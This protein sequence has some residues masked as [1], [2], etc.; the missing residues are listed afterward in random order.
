[1]SFIDKFINSKLGQG[2]VVA[3]LFFIVGLLIGLFVKPG[4]EIEMNKLTEDGF[5]K[6]KDG[7]I[8]EMLDKVKPDN[9]RQ[10]L[11]MLTKEPH[12]AALERDKELLTWMEKTW[13]KDFEL[14]KVDK[15]TYDVL[16]SYP[17]RTNPNKIRILNEQGEVVFESRHMETPLHEDDQHPNFIHAFN[18][19]AP[20]GDVTGDLVYVNYGRV[21][22]LQYLEKIGVSIEGKICI[23]RYGKIYR[24]NR[25]KNCQDKGA[26]GVIMFSDPA[27]VAVQGTKPENVYPNSIFLPGTGIQRG[28][29]YIGSGDPFSPGWPSVPH[30]YRLKES[31]GLPKI[32]SQPIGYDDAKKLLE[33]MGGQDPPE[34]WKGKV[35]GVSYKLGDA[36]KTGYEG[37]KV[38]L[39]VNNFLRTVPDTNLIGYI[40]GEVEPDRYVILSNHRDAWGYGSVDPS[41]GTAQMMEVVRNL[42]ALKKKGWRPR[43]TIIFC[44]WGSEEYGLI[45]STEFVTDKIHKLKDRAV[46]LVNTDVCVSGPIAKPGASPGIHGL[47]LDALRAASDPTGS[48][49]NYY[50]FWTKWW[51]SDKE[52]HEVPKVKLLTSGSDHDGFAF[53]A[54]VPSVDLKFKDDTKKYKGVGQYPMYH[55]GY[56]T[57]YLM[58]NIIDPDFHIHRTCA[59]TSIHLLLRFA[60]S[61]VV[62]YDLNEIP[63]EMEKGLKEIMQSNVTNDILIPA[64][65]TFKYVRAAINDF[66]IRCHEFMNNIETRSSSPY[67]LRALNDQLMYFQKVF[68]KEQDVIFAPATFNKYGSSVFPVLRDYY[69]E[70]DKL[71][72]EELRDR[73]EEI[74]RHLSDLMIYIQMASSYLGPIDVL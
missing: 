1:M 28:S 64:G 69:H 57:F 61:A 9:I 32:P 47:V 14:D 29:T 58:N 21:E 22:D 8:P 53:S 56:E 73:V 17:N 45:G 55:T 25:L 42:G 63:V 31:E 66:K 20:A 70:I 13:T 10:F 16:L 26:K 44:S 33:I 49:S 7:L 19:Y 38:R 2:I 36:K 65:V 40:K 41:S 5:H 59:Q 34:E 51:N 43:R 67:D 23:S 46:G 12:L 62:P 60:D 52:R 54:G 72:E 39:T 30:S 50:D 11:R 74:K 71:T 18:A 6:K 24:G 48:E 3:I 35:E 4:H 27:D 37:H 68:L 15:V